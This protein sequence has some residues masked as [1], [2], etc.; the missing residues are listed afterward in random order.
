MVLEIAFIPV[1]TGQEGAFAAAAE[2]ALAEVFPQAPGF[3]SGEVRRGVE[4]S[5]TFV[6]LLQ[7]RALEDHTE[8]FVQ[9]DLFAQWVDLTDGLI[10]GEPTVE[11]WELPLV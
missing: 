11:H 1:A 4:R 2:R 7:W 5:D 8:G 3:V 9:S 6:L 10:G